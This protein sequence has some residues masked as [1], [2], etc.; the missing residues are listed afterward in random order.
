ME[1]S[2]S[3]VA[4]TLYKYNKEQVGSQREAARTIR[5]ER[6]CA[7]HYKYGGRFTSSCA[8]K[9]FGSR[10]R[11]AACLVGGP[12]STTTTRTTSK[13]AQEVR[14]RQEESDGWCIFLVI[15]YANAFLSLVCVRQ[16]HVEVSDNV[17][18]APGWSTRFAGALARPVL[19]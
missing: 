3:F 7:K 16:T 18:P 2:S 4:Q 14:L 10:W 8:Q 15:V 12:C 5:L 9:L 13:K 11:Q 6:Q 17:S 19:R 1:L